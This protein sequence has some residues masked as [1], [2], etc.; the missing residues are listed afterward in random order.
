MERIM[1][2]EFDLTFVNANDRPVDET[3][4]EA[5]DADLTAAWDLP[6]VSEVS[7][8]TVREVEGPHEH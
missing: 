3:A 7:N 5:V 6:G 4:R 2:I 8:V 1:H